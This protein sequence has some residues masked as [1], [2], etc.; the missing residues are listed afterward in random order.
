MPT[1]KSI[2][3]AVAPNECP[4]QE[5]LDGIDRRNGRMWML[6]GLLLAAMAAAVVCLYVQQFW[7]FATPGLPAPETRGVL[8][9]GLCGLVLI[10][11]LYVL[12]RQR[13]LAALRVQLF[14]SRLKQE[15]LRSRL[16]E[17]SSLFDV[18]TSVN[19]EQRV[20]AILDIM[21]RRVLPCL[22][23]DQS[24]VL[25]LDGDAGILRCRAV[26]GV[27]ADFVRGAETKLGEGIAGMVA[28]TGEPIVVNPEDITARFPNSRKSGRN[29]ASALCIPLLWKGRVLGVL[30][31]NRIDRGLPFT[32]ADAKIVA[33]FAEHAASAL[34]KAEDFQE[35]DRRANLLE[36]A[37]RRL[38]ELNRM[39]E[40]FL[41][42]VSHEL[43][44]PLT[45]II[46]YA[47]FLL[48]DEAT[49]APDRRRMFSHIL[50]DQATRLLDLVNDI[51]DLSRLEGGALPLQLQTTAVNEVVASSVQALETEAVRKGIRLEQHLAPDL[52]TISV[53]T[54]KL[55][56]VLVNL[57]QNAVKFT[58]GGGRI[59]VAT[60]CESGSIVVEVADTGIGIA[61]RDLARVFDLFA[62]TEI[63]MQRNYEGLG[64]GL[65]LVKRLVEIHG[66]RVWVESA[67]GRGSRFFFSLPTGGV[68]D[69]IE[70]SRDRALPG[71]AG[72]TTRV[73]LPAPSVVGDTGGSDSGERAA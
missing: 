20:D 57:I 23:A 58:E 39:K 27:D 72:A 25:L 45:C 3:D 47:E 32:R 55:R 35:L 38:A 64:L 37:N 70:E 12:L 49:L 11:S 67:P 2:G 62:R 6:N 69:R 33:V 42:T 29:I 56:Q 9:T 71:V 10:F 43:K 44:T 40:I 61:A 66:G 30:N 5:Q 59:D 60:R 17:I 73:A 24:S 36:E 34:R 48:Q 18:A 13:E 46:A 22:E 50:H 51:L 14:Q 52:P 31:V 65:H 54:S 15:V 1:R 21:V 28:Q 53:D 7:G 26:Y 4:F 16:S 19:L 63:A 68:I 41:S 8:A